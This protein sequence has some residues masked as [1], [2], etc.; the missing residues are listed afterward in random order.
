M[1]WHWQRKSADKAC[2]VLLLLGRSPSRLRLRPRQDYA[3][4]DLNAQIP[5]FIFA[6][7]FFCRCN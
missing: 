2:V 7:R 4:V 3:R 1:S 6:G 5:G